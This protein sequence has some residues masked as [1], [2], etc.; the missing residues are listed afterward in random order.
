MTCPHFSN[1]VNRRPMEEENSEGA[2]SG[3]ASHRQV[4]EDEVTVTHTMSVLVYFFSH[5]FRMLQLVLNLTPGKKLN[6]SLSDRLLI[7]VDGSHV[8]EHAEGMQAVQRA[9][10]LMLNN[11]YYEAEAIVKPQ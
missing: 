7:V 2:G 6:V 1:S 8:V 5:S 11:H 4:E 3:T 9:I 10:S